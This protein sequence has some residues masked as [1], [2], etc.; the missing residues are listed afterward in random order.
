[1]NVDESLLAT[2]SYL[3][4]YIHYGV[5]WR[6]HP[7]NHVITRSEFDVKFIRN[8]CNEGCDWCIHVTVVTCADTMTYT[9]H[10]ECCDWCIYVTV[11][12]CA[13]TMTYIPYVFSTFY[14]MTNN[15][16]CDICHLII[17]GVG[18]KPATDILCEF[19]G[20]H[21]KRPVSG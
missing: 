4:F 11:V 3:D 9:L 12:T 17:S 21:C 10:N 19:D 14:C 1:M 8:K 7:P 16:N 15:Y 2:Q 13:D 20:C 6:R 18:V 5:G